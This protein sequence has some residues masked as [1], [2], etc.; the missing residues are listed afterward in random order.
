MLSTRGLANF[1]NEASLTLTEFRA[2]RL[3]DTIKERTFDLVR[4]IL[5]LE[6]SAPGK[7]DRLLRSSF[8]SNI[9]W[10]LKLTVNPLVICF[11]DH[12]AAQL[13]RKHETSNYSIKSRVIASQMSFSL[14]IYFF[15]FLKKSLSSCLTNFSLK[16]KTIYEVRDLPC[17]LYLSELGTYILESNK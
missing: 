16:E 1:E 4:S 5:H 11:R 12:E 3:T 8:H 14:F 2:S 13:R 6:A 7:F 15:F 9:A 10:S 17:V